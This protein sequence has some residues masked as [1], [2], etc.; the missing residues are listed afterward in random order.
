MSL[1]ISMLFLAVNGWWV[2]ATDRE[3]VDLAMAVATGD[4]R[5]LSDLANWFQVRST[6]I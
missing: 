3:L 4:R 2:E 1:A 6:A 5:D